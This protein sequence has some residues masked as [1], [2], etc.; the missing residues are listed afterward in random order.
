MNLADMEAGLNRIVRD[1]ELAKNF[2]AQINAA[3]LEIATDFDLPALKTITP[4]SLPV[5]TAAWL[6]D[7]PAEYHKG[8]YRC[9]NGAW[10][11]VV[12]KR[13][14]DALNGMDPDHDESETR[15]THVGVSD[16]GESKKIATYPKA[17]DTLYLY[18]YEK[19]TV[20]VN[21]GDVCVCIPAAYHERV[22]LSKCIIKNFEVFLDS[23]EDGPMKSVMYWKARY[24]EAMF[25]E[26]HG[27]IGLIN[28]LVKA[29]RK[30]PQRHGG[31]D[32]L[33]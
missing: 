8:L 5:T 15:V 7:L 10:E 14:L 30:R 12:I 18:C 19:P 25:G 27:D 33:P 17:N 20:L 24:R 9:L 21:P 11:T 28:Y 26:I 3:I 13:D 16:T 4:L 6:Y 23:I 32:P 31:R 1:S 2:T 29:S 22:I